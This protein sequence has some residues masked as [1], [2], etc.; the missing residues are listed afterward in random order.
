M[1]DLERGSETQLDGDGYATLPGVSADGGNE[2]L[3]H[4]PAQ[5]IQIRREV[6]VVDF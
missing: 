2:T 1:C 3:E 5:K 6:L 4:T